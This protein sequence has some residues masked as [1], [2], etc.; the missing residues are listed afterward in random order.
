[1]DDNQLTSFLMENEELL[2][3]W[4]R[5][6]HANPEL[7]F[8]EFETAEFISDRLTDM[9]YKVERGVGGTGVIATLETQRPGPV[10]AFRAD[11]DAL[12]IMESTDLP[13]ESKKIGIMHACG[14]DVHMTVLLGTA[15]VLSKAKDDFIGSVRFIF[16]PGEEA[17]GGA[18]CIIDAGALQNPTVEKIF[19][20]HVMPFIPVGQIAMKSGYMSA[21]DDEII[22]K[23][24]GTAAHSSEPETGTNAITMA[25]HAITAMQSIQTACISPHDIATFSICKIRGGEAINIIADTVEMS[26]M[27]RCIEKATKLK[28]REKIEQI[29]KNTALAFGGSVEIDFIE[30]FPAVYNDP[31][32]NEIVEIAA[33]EALSHDNVTEIKIPHLGSEDFS[34]YQE[35]I[36]GVMFMLGVGVTGEDRGLLH[37][38]SLNVHEDALTVGVKVFT[39]IARK[40]CGINRDTKTVE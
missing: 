5:H 4:R 12:P 16:Q 7:S 30:G 21:T 31:S 38:P 39:S 25:A 20:L 33:K 36:P 40:I 18:R 10:I 1:M 32:L 27:I 37:T 8:E 14:H 22:I 9:G 11:M 23:F 35:V 28:F 29:C 34:Y 2:I 13:Y 15:L 24:H 26:G 17:N 19:A 3:R 6:L